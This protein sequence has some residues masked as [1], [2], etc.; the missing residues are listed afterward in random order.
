MSDQDR[1]TRDAEAALV[2]RL[3]DRGEAS[4]EWLAAE[5]LAWLKATGWRPFMV[6]P[7]AADW[8]RASG[9]RAL[10]APLDPGVKER[11]LADFQAATDRHGTGAQPVIAEDGDDP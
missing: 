9:G 2:Q 1:A 6:V 7:P 10:G 3:R 5:Y 4:D 8:R 11:L